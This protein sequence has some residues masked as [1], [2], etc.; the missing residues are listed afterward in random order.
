METDRHRVEIWRRSHYR[1][2]HRTGRVRAA[3]KAHKARQNEERLRAGAAWSDN[4]L[5]FATSIGN[6][7]YPSNVLR[8]FA[9]LQERAGVPHIGFHHLR[10]T[11]ATRLI[12]NGRPITTVSER[13]GHAK[14]SI[15]LDEYAHVVA[16][17]REDAAL[18]VSALQFGDEA[19][20]ARVG[21]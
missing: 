14:S 10:H 19:E 8:N 4:D 12:T 21:S 3:L 2:T 13:P 11:H 1:L 7:A 18:A 9:K 20:T 5:V 15:T 17:T 6:S 16:S